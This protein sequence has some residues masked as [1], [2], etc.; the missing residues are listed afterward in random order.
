MTPLKP[1]HP[2]EI[3]REEYMK[4]LKIEQQAICRNTG[5]HPK[6][7]RDLLNQK[8]GITPTIALRLVSYFSR[9]TP[10][11]WMNIQRTYEAQLAEYRRMKDQENPE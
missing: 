2:G 8:I 5:I 4:P 1:V 3:L 11:F 7:L 10:E 6:T 9:T